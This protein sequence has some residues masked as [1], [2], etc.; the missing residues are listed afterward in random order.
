MPK[1]VFSPF[2][3]SD[4]RSH[5]RA[6]MLAFCAMGFHVGVWAVLLAD[7]AGSL[8]LSPG[9][10]GVALTCQSAAGVVALLAGGRLADR[11]GRRPLLVAG[12][13][14]TGVYLALLA[15]VESY[16]ALLAVL[17]FSGVVGLYDLACNA[18]GGDHERQ[19]DVKAMTL[20]HAGFSGSAALGA[21][22]SGVALSAGIGFG[23]VY[24]ISGGGILLFAFAATRLP[25]PRRV[26]ET[27]GEESSR[28]TFDLLRV[29]AVLACVAIIFMC[30]STDAALEG[31]TSI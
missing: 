6:I 30:F 3:T 11:F 26:A 25:L 20:F 7:L 27:D 19:H 29:P 4:E 17:V 14:G 18:L 12:V 23:T 31:Y 16:G 8:S 13:A 2:E 15:F 9:V 21:F 5:F 10:L 28:R 1:R 24:V 22:G